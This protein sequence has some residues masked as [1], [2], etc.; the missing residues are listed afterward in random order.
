MWAASDDVSTRS[1]G[2]ERIGRPEGTAADSGL[3]P[4]FASQS[5]KGATNS[6]L[7]VVLPSMVV[8]NDYKRNYDYLKTTRDVP[9]TAWKRQ[10]TEGCDLQ[11]NLNVI[12]T[13]FL[14]SLNFQYAENLPTN[15]TA[16]FGRLRSPANSSATI[17]G[18]RRQKFAA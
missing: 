15:A 2:W 7:A 1:D 10:R 12:K 17:D 6:L 14:T 8:D 13:K 3:Q 11:R 18:N 9:R 5:T 16:N 4:K